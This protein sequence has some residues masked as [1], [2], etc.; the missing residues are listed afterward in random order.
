MSA[1][2]QLAPSQELS[3]E[4]AVPNL[5][6]TAPAERQRRWLQY[7][8]GAI[9]LVVLLAAIVFGVMV[10]SKRRAYLRRI[11]D[12]IERTNVAEN[13]NHASACYSELFALVG[14]DG[15][16]NLLASEA[17]SIAV[18]AAWEEVRRTV[19]DS[20]DAR[21]FRPDEEK[22]AWFVQFLESRL[23]TKTPTWW[24]EVVQDAK[25]FGRDFVQ[26][27]DPT[28]S[29]YHK[30][31]LLAVESPRGVTLQAESKTITLTSGSD[32]LEIP[33]SFARFYGYRLTHWAGRTF[34]NLSAAFTKYRCFL[35]L[36]DDIGYGPTVAC[37][38]RDSGEV[39][40]ESHACGCF[41]DTIARMDF[42]DAWVS[43]FIHNDRVILY[44]KS[45]QGVYAHAFRQNDGK[46]LFRFSSSF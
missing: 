15:L 14:E 12:A 41:W 45:F 24:A 30:S 32:V 35:T 13:S 27:G 18:Q 3:E 46:T 29:P 36:H 7:S 44:G 8:L 23:S 5:G 19:P 20:E 22:L 28:E 21:V 4:N 11:D 40:W 2:N 1:E 26:P 39:L 6:Q 42:R 10:E 31:G 25:W 43:V 38:D 34:H 17:D 16:G 9:L 33:T 37:I